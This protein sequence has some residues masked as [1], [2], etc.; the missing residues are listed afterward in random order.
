MHSNL[1]QHENDKKYSVTGYQTLEE[2]IFKQNIST[3]S[4]KGTKSNTFMIVD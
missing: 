1:S 3:D 4:F 2:Q